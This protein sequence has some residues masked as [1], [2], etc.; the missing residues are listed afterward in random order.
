MLVFY[1][2]VVVTRGCRRYIM[3]LLKGTIAAFAVTALLSSVGVNAESIWHF[4]GVTLEGHG[5]V[6]E[7]SVHE[8]DI[9]SPQYFKNVSAYDNE[10]WVERAMKVAIQQNSSTSSSGYIELN[11]GVTGIFTGAAVENPNKYFVK[12]KTANWLSNDVYFN[13]I[14]YLDNTRL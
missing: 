3:K 11:T 8:K 12:L 2:I 7:S 14:W 10:K 1:A 6:N 4:A 9:E 13:G 5:K